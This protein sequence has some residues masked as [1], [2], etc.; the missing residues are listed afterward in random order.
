MV[1]DAPV[2]TRPASRLA[3]VVA[4]ERKVV[5]QPDLVF[6]PRPAHQ[7][8]Y[9]PDSSLPRPREAGG[10]KREPMPLDGH[11]WTGYAVRATLRST[12]AT[13]ASS[14]SGLVLSCSSPNSGGG[15]L[16]S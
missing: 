9:P 15:R 5:P 16:Q 13:T 10:W 14:T 7:N 6:P 4:D 12:S 3:L 11:S 2:R 8:L 1:T